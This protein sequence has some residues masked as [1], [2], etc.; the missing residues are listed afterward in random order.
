MNFSQIEVKEKDPVEY[1]PG[2]FVDL[3]ID[4]GNQR[5][6]KVALLAVDKAIYALNA[7]NKLTQKQVWSSRPLHAALWRS[8]GT[9]VQV[10]QTH[11]RTFK[12]ILNAKKL[13]CS[14]TLPGVAQGESMF[15]CWHLVVTGGI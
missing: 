10:V 1:K 12:L 13:L 8:L 6:A 3:D 15:L 5:K 11:F 9:P 7:Q 2:S 4:A 14:K